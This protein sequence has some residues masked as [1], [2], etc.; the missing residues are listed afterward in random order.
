M[1]PPHREE[2]KTV[3]PLKISGYTGIPFHR[4]LESPNLYWQYVPQSGTQP[5]PPD[6]G[7][8]RN[9]DTSEGVLLFLFMAPKVTVF[10]YSNLSQSL[11]MVYRTLF[12]FSL[13]LG[14]GL[15]GVGADEVRSHH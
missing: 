1:N 6:Y 12:L 14:I 11:S 15:P 9:F 10:N 3:V 5:T 2:S 13:L 4:S 8:S 7:W